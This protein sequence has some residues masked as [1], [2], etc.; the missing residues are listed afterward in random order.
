MFWAIRSVFTSS[1]NQF[2]VG[3]NGNANNNKNNISNKKSVSFDCWMKINGTLAIWNKIITFVL[4]SMGFGL[5]SQFSII[6][7]CILTINKPSSNF[8][9]IIRLMWLRSVLVWMIVVR[10]ITNCNQCPTGLNVCF[11]FRLK[12]I[13]TF[14]KLH[15]LIFFS[16][17]LISL[18]LDWYSTL[19]EC[20]A[21]IDRRKGGKRTRIKIH[22]YIW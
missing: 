11:V 12:L 13:F 20:V 15:L 19:Y 16:F 18:W 17:S 3:Y 21:S 6:L 2:N 1:I 22:K 5:P 14:I 8:E 4:H 7:V 10:W 9:K